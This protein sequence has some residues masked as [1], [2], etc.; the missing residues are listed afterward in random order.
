MIDCTTAV[1][2]LWD[3]IELE[4]DGDD[5]ANMEEHLAFCKRCCG[6]LE[7][8]EELRGVLKSAAEP[9]LPQDA[10]SRLGRFI[11]EIERQEP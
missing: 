11:D 8:A 1:K 4:M 10:A 3:F 5:K 6:E 9:T 7:F 2:Q